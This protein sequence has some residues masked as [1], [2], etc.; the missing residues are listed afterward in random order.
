MLTI[1]EVI[2][3]LRPFDPNA[4]AEKPLAEAIAQVLAHKAAHNIESEI[5]SDLGGVVEGAAAEP[6]EGEQVLNIGLK[7]AS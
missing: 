2:A 3:F 4:D 1:A 7:P 6:T 5:L